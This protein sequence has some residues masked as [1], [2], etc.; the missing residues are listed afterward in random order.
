MLEPSAASTSLRRLYLDDA[1]ACEAIAR[2]HGWEVGEDRWR[3]MIGLDRGW[4]VVAPGA[5]LVG[6]TLLFDYSGR[7]A[8]VA[9][10]LVRAAF[11][12]QGVA[13]RLVERALRDAPPATYLYSTPQGRGLYERLGFVA[14]EPLARYSGVPGGTPA[15]EAAT[16]RTLG[17]GE[18]PLAVRL[19]EEAFGASRT[20]AIAG[21]HRFAV[22][23]LGAWRG[24]ELVGY[25]LA[26]SVGGHV[27][28]GPVV[29]L[30]E[31]VGVQIVAALA[32]RQDVP[33]RIDAP[34][35]LSL[36]RG[37]AGHAGLEV[38]A[39]VPLMSL[40]GRELPGRRERIIAVASRGLG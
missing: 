14:R 36:L 3:L 25:G 32:E 22:R 26:T 24:E 30:E 5:G 33:V 15:D 6:T 39:P 28:I 16:L 20:D 37:W 7:V 13:G 17:S 27:A 19:D 12:R 23:A 18:L 4:G 2:E 40:G 29:A 9:M 1:P 10:V 35:G 21:L 31:R 8:L 34:A 38:G 11:G